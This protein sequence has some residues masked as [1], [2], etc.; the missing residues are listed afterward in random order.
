MMENAGLLICGLA[1]GTIAALIA[2]APHV[3]STESGVGWGMIFAALATIA[4][5]GLISCAIAAKYVVKG[6]LVEAL[7]EE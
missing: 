4:A 3:L 2:V 6:A 1:C 5:T 7:R